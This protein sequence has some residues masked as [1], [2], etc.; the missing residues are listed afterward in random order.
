MLTK[1]GLGLTGLTFDQ[2]TTA[3]RHGCVI[4]RPGLGV[5]I[6]DFHGLVRRGSHMPWAPTDAD[7]RATDWE[8]VPL[9]SQP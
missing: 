6:R 4:T 1:Q 3:A 5:E 9:E 7:V 2:A 8:I